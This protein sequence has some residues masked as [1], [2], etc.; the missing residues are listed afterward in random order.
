MSKLC[1]RVGSSPRRIG[2]AAPARQKA[3]AVFFKEASIRLGA[4]A[5]VP[6]LIAP[7][8]YC[9]ANHL[10]LCGAKA[11]ICM[12]PRPLPLCCGLARRLF[13]QGEPARHA[14]ELGDAVLSPNAFSVG[15]STRRR[16]VIV[17]SAYHLASVPQRSRC[18]LIEATK[19][20]N[21][22]TCAVVAA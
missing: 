10:G 11:S 15:H 18:R 4:G 22:L 9:Q 8:S 3:G 19:L 21:P 20:N 1:Y 7:V 12:P 2:M 17:W 14:L 5:I 16:R 6:I 13:V